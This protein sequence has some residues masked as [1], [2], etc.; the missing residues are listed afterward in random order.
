MRVCLLTSCRR[1]ER[2]QS[3]MTTLQ[4]VISVNA[5]MHVSIGL[6]HRLC[7]FVCVCFGEKDADEVNGTTGLLQLLSLGVME[8]LCKWLLTHTH[9]HTRDEREEVGRTQGWI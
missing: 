5:G 1:V 8:G 2:P 4:I 9:T 3:Q 6:V 7:V